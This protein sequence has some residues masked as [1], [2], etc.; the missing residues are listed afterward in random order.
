MIRD[1]EKPLHDLPETRGMTAREVVRRALAA[2]LDDP[3][4]EDWSLEDRLEMAA[5]MFE[6]RLRI[7][8]FQVLP[9]I[10]VPTGKEGRT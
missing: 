5:A 1:E 4:H 6:G 2:A 3:P 10:P 7:C 9:A 8:G